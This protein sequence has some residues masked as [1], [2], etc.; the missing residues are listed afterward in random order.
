MILTPRI[1]DS[2]SYYSDT[3]VKTDEKF[4]PWPSG[5]SW[6]WRGGG[7][8]RGFQGSSPK[9]SSWDDTFSI[10]TIICTELDRQQLRGQLSNFSW[11]ALDFCFLFWLFPFR[12]YPKMYEN[13]MITM[14][15]GVFSC[16]ENTWKTWDR[17]MCVQSRRRGKEEGESSSRPPE[18]WAGEQ[19]VHPGGQVTTW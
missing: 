11:S 3:F 13:N 6:S 2:S 7:D 5:W 12:L 18:R 14:L 10:V 9:S 4:W 16:F 1:P 17:A 8:R 19:V 15:Y